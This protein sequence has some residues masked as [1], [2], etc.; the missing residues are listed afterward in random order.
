MK[1][2]TS[3]KHR[4]KST[5]LDKGKDTAPGHVWQVTEKGD[6]KIIRYVEFWWI[7]TTEGYFISAA[8][9]QIL[10]SCINSDPAERL[11]NSL[12]S[13]SL[14]QMT[15][16]ITEKAWVCLPWSIIQVHTTT[17]ISVTTKE[18]LVTATPAHSYISAGEGLATS[19]SKVMSINPRD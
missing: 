4:C 2:H 11:L 8:S 5:K 3:S 16:R 17:Y 1:H 13:F 10:T 9:W 14:T 12:I 15:L 7:L 18:Y 19:T 6:S